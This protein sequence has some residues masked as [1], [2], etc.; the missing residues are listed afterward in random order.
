MESGG[1]SRSWNR[2]LGG[3]IRGQIAD[4][5]PHLA[6]KAGITVVDVPA[7]GTSSGCPRCN[8]NLRHVM[9]PD[10]LTVRGHKWAYCPSCNFSADRDYSAAQ[11]IVARGLSGQHLVRRDRA[12]LLHT[13]TIVDAPVRA[14]RDKQS[15]TPRR[16]RRPQVS[17]PTPQRRRVPAIPAPITAAQR[18]AGRIPQTLCNRT[19][20]GQVPTAKPASHQPQGRR[21]GR[22][23]HRHVTATP[24][25]PPRR[26]TPRLNIS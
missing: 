7:R 21:L 10:R 24:V 23:F 18:P 5:L 16:P 4:A 22:G 12:G 20:A 25:A 26:R 2:R 8:A 9:S 17:R 13:T 1:L 3:H 14:V 11:R 6:A 15:A 19:V